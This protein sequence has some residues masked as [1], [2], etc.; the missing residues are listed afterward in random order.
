M[1][2]IISNSVIV[3]VIVFLS[4]QIIQ[5]QGVVYLSNLGQAANG[6]LAVGSNSWLAAGFITGTNVGGYALNSVQLGMTDASNN[7]SGFKVMVYSEVSKTG[8][9]PGNSLGILTGSLNPTAGGI[10]TFIPV[11]GL[12]LSSDTTYFIVL[13]AGTAVAN[14]AYGWSFMN[15]SSYNPGD[16]WLGTVTLS[17]KDGTSLSWTRLGS[18]P[19]Y[20]FSQYAI[21]ATA[22]PEPGVLSLLGLGGL[23]FLWQRRKT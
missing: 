5:A 4:P 8:A 9:F 14:G 17:S 20:D 7:P 21:N 22:I 1:K 3:F 6:S 13:T 15:Q 23:G 16:S 19:Q 11:S 2:K 10:Y 18:S 12:M